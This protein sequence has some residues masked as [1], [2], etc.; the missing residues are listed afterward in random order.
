VDGGESLWRFH[1]PETELSPLASGPTGNSLIGMPTRSSMGSVRTV[2]PLLSE[3]RRQRSRLI[4]RAV[5]RMRHDLWFLLISAASLV[6]AY[7][8]D[9]ELVRPWAASLHIPLCGP[10]AVLLPSGVAHA[11]VHD[12]P[13]LAICVSLLWMAGCVTFLVKVIGMVSSDSTFDNISGISLGRLNSQRLL[14]G[15]LDSPTFR[16]CEHGR[17]QDYLRF[18]HRWWRDA[19]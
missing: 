5:C 11:I 17:G 3:E 7:H 19:M 1:P 18:V 4:V 2:R 12:A 6:I 16:R 13:D 9:P 14:N 8:A 10:S 15:L